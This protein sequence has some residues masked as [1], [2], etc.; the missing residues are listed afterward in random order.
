MHCKSPLDVTRHFIHTHMEQRDLEAALACL[1]DKIEW[2][3]TGVF[4]VVHGKEEARRF[5]VGEIT[6]FPAG[7]QVDFADITETM[8]TE[9][10]GT[11]LGRVLLTDRTMGSQLSCRITTTCVRQDGRFLLAALHLS[12]PTVLQNDSEY[13]PLTIAAQKVE[14][15]QNSF[16]D[17]TLPGGLVACEVS[18]GFRVRYVNDF[19]PRLLGY[20]DKA[21][22][23]S[24]VGGCFVNCF[25][26]GEDIAG[27]AQ[28]VQ[29]MEVGG[30]HTFTYR[31]KKKSG[32]ELW[33]RGYTYK[34]EDRGV[35]AVLCFCMDI[36]DIIALEDRLKEQKDRLEFANAEIQTIVSNIPGG[37]HR[38]PLFDRIY[39]NYI[40]QGF[41]E[42]SG[43]T[44]AEI[45][46]LFDDKYTMLL[47]EEDRNA[48]AEA[49]YQLSA[50]P[51]DR[52]LEYR[53]RRKD[54]TVIHVVD[55]FRSV[56]MEDGKM[57]GFGVATDVT[58]QHEALAQLQ[59]LTDSIPGGLVVYE[60]APAGLS[61]VYFSDGVCAMVGYTRAEYTAIARTNMAEFV[62]PEDLE[63]LR[64]KLAEVAAGAC[65]VDCVYRHRTKSGG[66]RWL[67]V[68][69]TVSDRWG[70]V[71]RVNAVLLD[72]T[73][74]KEAE[75]KLRIRDEE[76]SLAIQQ[77]GKVVYR[78]TVADK[79]AVMLQKG[80]DLFA[81]PASARNVPESMI[82]LNL[83]APESVADLMS[84]YAAIAA[85]EKAGCVTLSRRLKDGGFGWC[86]AHFT[87]LFS[88]IGVPMSAVISIENVTKQ[89]EQELALGRMSQH[90]KQL[91]RDSILYFEANLTKVKITHA[92]GPSLPCITGCLDG[93]PIQMLEAAIQ[94][95]IAQKDQ[96]DIRRFFNR[97]C[98]LDEFARGNTE[99]ETEAHVL[100]GEHHKWVRITVELVADP[101]T[102]DVLGYVLFRDINRTKIRELAMLKQAETDGLT[103]LY[104][105]TAI[106]V[107]IK[108]LL[109]TAGDSPCALVMVDVDDLKIINDSLGHLQGDRAIRSFADILR[110]HFGPDALVGRMGG[111][112]FLVFFRAAVDAATLS[113][114]LQALVEKL[115][116]LRVG[117][118]EDYP[119]HGS[120][121]A[122]IGRTGRDTFEALYKQADTALY[123]VKRHGKNCYALYR[124]DITRAEPQTDCCGN[125]L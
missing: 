2:F 49:I 50:E 73:E 75:D 83:F 99:K 58:A 53:M 4:E 21:E 57:W 107:K 61:T 32:Q 42:L 90:V 62:F 80:A 69:G 94:R 67:N 9:D 22:F 23:L 7:Y 104:N 31:V 103:E 82:A 106:E 88:S 41:E 117:E 12:L 3:G 95:L 56:R 1:T 98:L 76:Y 39:V 124:A 116:A 70:D 52:V 123:D 14:E 28:E 64:G 120:I 93:E 18:E 84:F 110:S 66:Y 17:M 46:T 100:C 30:H 10:V 54:G 81:F 38:C 6:A 109:E 8:L 44:K 119:I 91:S 85:G 121:G 102:E 60:Y 15:I 51:A 37:V 108:Q 87:T 125:P 33:F 19:L 45:H 89:H 25:G 101:Y 27:M 16:F 111:D 40:S 26:A 13:Y 65:S 68:R 86:R 20:S 79:S 118:G 74:G 115:S 105:R 59:L 47:L 77:G 122:A 35:A 112:E 36:S 71:V 92:G 72:I 11:V 55:R 63:F 43:Y 24:A 97:D 113:E 114:T 34:Y 48:F 96:A 29:S 5:L 78:Y